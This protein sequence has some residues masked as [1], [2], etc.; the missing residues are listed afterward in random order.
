MK[1][2]HKDFLGLFIF[3]VLLFIGWVLVDGPNHS[4]KT[5]DAY[6]K[7]QEPLAPINSGSTYNSFKE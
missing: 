5:G 1:H 6:N 2:H 7:Y 4:K 3:F